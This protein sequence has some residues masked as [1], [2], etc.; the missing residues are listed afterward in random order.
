MI[1]ELEDQRHSGDNEDLSK[2]VQS[3]NKFSSTGVRI[4]KKEGEKKK[5]KK[6][7]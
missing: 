2:P 4:K 1:W 3:V 5:K 6:D 7:N